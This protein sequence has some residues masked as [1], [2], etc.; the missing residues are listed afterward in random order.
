MYMYI[1]LLLLFNCQVLVYSSKGTCSS[2][3]WEPKGLVRLW[4][5]AF[6]LTSAA[7]GIFAF[8]SR[9][10]DGLAVYVHSR[11]GESSIIIFMYHHSTGVKKNRG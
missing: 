1:Y 8:L 9:F 7:A 10:H 5:A 3:R 2:C 4:R 11:L 6:V